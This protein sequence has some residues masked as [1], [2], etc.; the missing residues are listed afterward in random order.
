MICEES[1]MVEIPIDKIKDKIM[2][3]SLDQDNVPNFFTVID[4]CAQV[5]I[6]ITCPISSSMETA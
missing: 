3:A 1:D 6:K 5:W 2:C 4:G